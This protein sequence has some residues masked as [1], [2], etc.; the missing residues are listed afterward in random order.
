MQS[1]SEMNLQNPMADMT[2]PFDLESDD[3]LRGSYEISEVMAARA[4]PICMMEFCFEWN[5]QRVHE[6]WQE[7]C[8]ANRRLVLFA[9]VEHGK[10]SQITFGRALW[11]IGR[12]PSI[13]AGA[14]SSTA[15]LVERQ[16][17][18]VKQSIELHPRVHKVFPWL[19]QEKR[20]GRLKAWYANAIIVE[21]PDITSKDYTYQ[22][23]GVLGT[24]LGSR[25]DLMILDDLLDFENTLTPGSRAR[26]IEWLK[27][28]AITRLTPQGRIWCIGTA[29]HEE[30]LMH[31]MAE[32]EEYH[33]ERYDADDLLWPNLE[34]IDGKEVGWPQWR[35]DQRRRELGEIEYGRTMKNLALSDIMRIFDPDEFD[36]CVRLDGRTE[37]D[38]EWDGQDQLPATGVDLA[39]KKGEEHDEACFFTASIGGDNL[40]RVHDIRAGKY[41]LKGI[42]RNMVAV[43]R[44]FG[45]H[46]FIVENNAAQDYVCQ[47]VRDNEEI[48]LA[49]GIEVEGSLLNH[50]RVVPFTTGKQKYDPAIGVRGM[51]PSL[52]QHLWRFPDVPEVRKLRQE[53]V[54]WS[55]SSKMGD[56]LAA[57]WFWWSWARSKIRKSA[58]PRALTI[59]GQGNGKEGIQ[60]RPI[61]RIRFKR[62][63]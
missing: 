36:K 22:A 24:I 11:E 26:L 32:N 41:E 23:L 30:D 25:L 27:T 45:S 14:I 19:R 1:H 18:L 29:W 9:P 21:R 46:W 5:C 44:L 40:F 56:R 13:R 63:V 37:F 17:G 52:E 42:L 35:L 59:G 62:E 58:A 15:V 16:L 43:W 53:L 8:E 39:V 57:M 7:L 2:V 50:I 47:L 48:L 3:G 34:V 55:P 20:P 54:R 12:N 31:W 4:D 6:E 38:L 49:M 28:T 61:P 60:R 10:S 33:A 51:V